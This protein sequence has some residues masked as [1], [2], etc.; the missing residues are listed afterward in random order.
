[1]TYF[2]E[3]MSQQSQLMALEPHL[4]W[5][6]LNVTEH[7]YISGCGDVTETYALLQNGLH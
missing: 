1:M 6:T 5:R 4:L 7:A 2:N 3:Q